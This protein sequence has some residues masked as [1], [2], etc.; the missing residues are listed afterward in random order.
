MKM[1]DQWRENNVDLNK[2][3]E[4]V[5]QFFNRGHFQSKLE[6][7]GNGYRIEAATEKISNV[8]LQI[9]VDI[10]GEPNDFS[11]E[12]IADKRKGFF[13]PLMIAGY[14]ATALGGGIIF[15]SEMKLQEALDKLE[16]EF[17]S[18]V[19]EQVALLTN[20]ALK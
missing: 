11:I 10:L 14:I 6:K 9:S 19:D 16:K 13:S 15:R 8:Q 1:R 4:G 2:L 17:W 12:F 3:S 5:K 7:T 18:H 20:S